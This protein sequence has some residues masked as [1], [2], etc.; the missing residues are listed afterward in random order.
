MTGRR[1][2]VICSLVGITLIVAKASENDTGGARRPRR[3]REE[4][5]YSLPAEYEAGSTTRNTR[6][7]A[8][9]RGKRVYTMPL[10]T[11]ATN[12]FALRSRSERADLSCDSMSL[13]V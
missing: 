12:S 8:R 9:L 2:S 1:A 3:L 5:Y 6:L 4:R 11:F 7:S 13:R 10:V